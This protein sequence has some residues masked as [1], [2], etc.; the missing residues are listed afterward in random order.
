ML[1]RLHL[2]L[3]Q[4]AGVLAELHRDEVDRLAQMAVLVRAL[5]QT[6]R[7]GTSDQDSNRARVMFLRWPDG[8]VAMP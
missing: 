7:R 4:V 1:S 2:E 5:L 3:V 8:P 6:W